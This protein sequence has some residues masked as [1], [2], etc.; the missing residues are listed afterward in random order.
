MNLH[1]NARLTLASRREM[2]HDVIERRLTRCAAAAVYRVSVPTVV[3][4]VGRYLAQGEHALCNRPSA[5]ETA[6]EDPAF[7]VAAEFPLHIRGHP[8]GFAVTLADE[9][10]IGLEIA[11]DDAVE[12]RALRG[13]AGG[14]RRGEPDLV[15]RGPR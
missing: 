11:L 5:V 4:W 6:V 2:V 9:R 3:K 14:R 15:A 7:E 1:K 12:R 10:E 13:D 8:F